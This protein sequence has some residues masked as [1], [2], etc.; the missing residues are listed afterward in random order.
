MKI[1]NI[2][3]K[4]IPIPFTQGGNSTN[5]IAGDGHELGHLLIKVETDEGIT[6]YGEAFGFN[7][8]HTTKTAIDTL[9][10]PLVMGRDPLQI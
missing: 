8:I 10:A 7:A 6:G 5:F 1:T 2:E 4:P 9:I 3:A